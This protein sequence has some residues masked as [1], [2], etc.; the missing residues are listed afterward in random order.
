[1][2][3]MVTHDEML[4]TLQAHVA[5]QSTINAFLISYL[6]GLGVIEVD[7][8]Y[9]GLERVAGTLD[10]DEIMAPVGPLMRQFVENMREGG[11]RANGPRLRLVQDDDK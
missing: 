8:V 11:G 5:A 2:S 1:M 10:Q 4:V 9:E 3:D 7:D 6:A